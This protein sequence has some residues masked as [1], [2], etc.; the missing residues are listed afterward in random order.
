MAD[1]DAVVVGGGLAGLTAATL[2]A[3][4]GLDVVVLE[5]RDEVGGRTRSRT[6]AG[7]TV[8]LGAEHIGPNQHYALGLA[9]RLGLKLERTRL[10]SGRSLWQLD[11]DSKVGRL[12]PLPL[13]D[14]GRLVRVLGEL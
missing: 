8:D 6:V 10:L 9:K 11:G 1:R 4:R 7:T 12:P 13:R 3:S 2:L 14:I 5:A